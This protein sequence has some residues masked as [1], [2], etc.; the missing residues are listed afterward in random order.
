MNPDNS[1]HSFLLDRKGFTTIDVP[2]AIGTNAL[3]INP[4][5]EIVG[6]YVP[7]SGTGRGFLWRRGTFSDIALPGTVLD[8]ANGINARGDV[9]GQ[10]NDTPGIPQHGYLLS[11]GISWRLTFQARSAPPRS[12]S[13]SVATSSGRMSERTERRACISSL[14]VS[15]RRSMCQER[16]ERLEPARRA[17]LP[18]SMRRVTLSAPIEG[19]TARLAAFFGMPTASAQLTFP[20]RCSRA[21]Q[22]SIHKGTSSASIAISPAGTTA[23]CFGADLRCER[24]SANVKLGSWGCVSQDVYETLDAGHGPGSPQITFPTTIRKGREDFARIGRS[25]AVV[26]WRERR[27]VD[28]NR[29]QLEPSDQLAAAD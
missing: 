22:E 15:S 3:R 24:E 11:K 9:V 10:Y 17:H 6:F 23:F 29:R 18:G 27:M 2:G 12:T 5:G 4:Q 26:S 21:P 7:S 28:Q 19:P 14:R 25:D 1:V 16:S 20:T 13:T 8:F